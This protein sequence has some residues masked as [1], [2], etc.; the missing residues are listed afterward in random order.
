MRVAVCGTGQLGTFAAGAFAEAGWEVAASD[1]AADA[2]YF[3][4][5]GRA[6]TTIAA[7]D[8]T[9]RTGLRAWLGGQPPADALV[10][11]A[12]LTG[13]RAAQDPAGARDLALASAANTVEAAREAGARR[14]V[15]IS[16]LAVY[17]PDGARSLGEDGPLA[18]ATDYGA[19]LVEMERLLGERAGDLDVRVLRV[20]GVFGPI[21]YGHGSNSARA[22]ERLVYAAATGRPVTVSAY[23][24]DADDYVYVRDVA[25]AILAVASAEPAA[26]VVTYNVGTGATTTATELLGA[27][28]SLFPDATIER[29]DPDPPRDRLRRPPLDVTRLRRLGWTPR[30]PLPE[31]LRDYCATVDLAVS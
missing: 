6:A 30:W 16:S 7:V 8:L 4:R 2:A 18:P 26:G 31:A 1:L 9:D 24:D 14:L 19:N 29:T 17:D 28:A 11:T 20:A 10:V 25:G 3:T 15:A 12:G 27:L 23:P 21:R 13:P 5:F 22:I